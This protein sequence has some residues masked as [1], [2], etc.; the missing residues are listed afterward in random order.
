MAES[1]GSASGR[2]PKGSALWA[3]PGGSPAEREEMLMEQMG[4]G[5]KLL[6]GGDYNPEQWLDSPEVLEE[7][8]RLM[9]QA[10]VNCVSMGM[11]AWGVLEPE[12]GR[13]E[14]DW[15]EGIVSRLY[16]NGIYTILATPTG[17]VPPWMAAQYEEVRQTDENGVRL[18]AGNRHN[19]CP[20]APVMRAKARAVDEALSRRLGRHPG[21]IGWH[22]SNEYGGNGRWADCHCE[23][24]QQAF[25][26][27]LQARYGTLDAL[28]KAW[29]TRF[30]SH[31]YTD[32]QQIH[33][34]SPRGE[35]SLHGLKLDWKRFVSDQLLDFCKME[36]D[37]VRVYS[38][39][40]VTTNMMRFFAPLDYFKWAKV[41]DVISWDNYPYWHSGPDEIGEAVETAAAHTLMRSLK[42]APF[43]MMESTPSVVNWRPV[44]TLKRPGM[45]AL[46]S[47]Q[48]VAHGSNS[49]QYFQWRKSRGS[50]EK[51]HGAVIDHK[52]GADT[53]VFRDVASLGERLE[54]L[55]G[56][57]CRSCN[58]PAVAMVFDW[59]NMWAVQDAC[60][61][62]KPLDYQGLFLTYFR[63]FWEQGVDVD[64]VDMDG[65]LDGYALVAAPL[66][67]MYK[68]GYAEKVRAF[69]ER[70]GVYVTT[71]W[72]G[73]VDENDLCFLQEHPL[74]DVL[75]IRTEEIDAPGPYWKNAVEYA[76]HRYAVTGL[77]ALVHA[78]S[79]S[80]LAAYTDDFYQGYPALTE[81]RF[82]KG[83]AYFIASQNEQ[84]AI[85]AMT[86]RFLRRAGVS[87]GF[88]GTL[89]AGVT[90]SG[91]VIESGEGQGQLL[92]FL[93]N[94]NREGAVVPL[95][96]PYRDMETGAEW[97]SKVE[98][99]AFSCVVLAETEPPVEKK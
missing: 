85:G 61:V 77:C 45:H 47:L 76:G 21:V 64:I 28:N 82:G 22:L 58:R 68:P 98:M 74:R 23:H 66:N 42:K 60:A 1:R 32:W 13:Y 41:L 84:A 93:Q 95:F 43:L 69:V 91:R 52:N 25:R 20:S 56:P 34:P 38:D 4:Q 2:I 72:S 10:H 14:L 63:A 89:P 67:Y 39:L 5:M 53:R 59:E 40:P 37:A 11:F 96:A 65:A 17:A 29:W 73:E 19:F 90:V 92:W 8:I 48:A 70:G 99:P 49:V 83:A 81:N 31:T 16:E 87:C 33:S 46:S 12:N 86:D 78:E 71:Y 62:E 7:D 3:G 54:K 24:C 44:N 36:A 30:W 18:L 97:E 15:L 55:S 27:W 94:F 75:G 50:C 6:H 57:V 88:C 79:A 51:Y 35:S 9:R 80:V 26:R